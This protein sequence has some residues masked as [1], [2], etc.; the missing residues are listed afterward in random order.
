MQYGLSA[1]AP[2]ATVL[3]AVREADAQNPDLPVVRFG[4][5]AG[6]NVGDNA[7][8]AILENPSLSVRGAERAAAAAARFASAQPADPKLPINENWDDSVKALVN[9]PDIV[10]KMST[11]LDWTSALG[12]AVVADQGAVL[13]AIQAFR[14]KTESVGNLK[15]D[16]KQTVVVEC[17]GLKSEKDARGPAIA[18]AIESS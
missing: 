8:R 4:L 9:Y 15:S 3:R 18:D 7:V 16:A 13:E 12:E 1:E 6:K 14:R 10:K 2:L 5:S 11:D 17:W